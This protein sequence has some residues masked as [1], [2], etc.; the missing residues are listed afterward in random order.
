MFRLGQQ[1][2]IVIGLIDLP[3]RRDQFPGITPDPHVNVLQM[4]G[5]DDDFHKVALDQ[6]MV[7]EIARDANGWNHSPPGKS[8]QA[9]GIA[10][11]G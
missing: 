5:G 9:E 11:V 8:R 6:L 10:P 4:P 1:N 7:E 2:V 3:Q